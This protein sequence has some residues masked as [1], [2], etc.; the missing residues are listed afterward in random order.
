VCALRSFADMVDPTSEVISSLSVR[1]DD[2]LY[3]AD[4]EILI[5]WED[6]AD[7]HVSN[8]ASQDRAQDD[9]GV[10][11]ISRRSRKREVAQWSA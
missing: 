10:L 2:R 6:G 3:V 4:V 7:T 9:A 11:K 8:G 5:D 1:S